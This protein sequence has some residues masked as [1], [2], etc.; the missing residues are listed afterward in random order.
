MPK[1]TE[2]VALAT[3][4]VCDTGFLVEFMENYVL[5]EEG[6]K[7]D[8]FVEVATTMAEYIVRYLSDTVEGVF[9]VLSKLITSW[10]LLGVQVKD[11]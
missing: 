8:G 1:N 9:I 3:L 6:I 10:I 11:I 5:E 2:R 4:V 7:L